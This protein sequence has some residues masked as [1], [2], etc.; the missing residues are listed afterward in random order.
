MTTQTPAPAP[1]EGGRF[2]AFM[3]WIAS[4]LT[5]TDPARPSEDDSFATTLLTDLAQQLAARLGME[6]ALV[7]SELIA[8]RRQGTQ[9]EGIR[10]LLR[11]ECSVEKLTSSRIKLSLLAAQGSP[12]KAELITITK[13]LNWDDL[14]K[15]IRRE[16][17]LSAERELHYVLC[18]NQDQQKARTALPTKT[19]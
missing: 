8:W 3:A 6:P 16:F 1:P 9:S 17:N 15:G 2:A 19:S 13:E 18:P 10:H 4:C 14:P 5:H 11:V 7:A 12:A